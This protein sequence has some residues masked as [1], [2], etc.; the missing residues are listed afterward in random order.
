MG[1][2]RCLYRV[3]DVAVWQ[4]GFGGVFQTGIVRSAKL[5]GAYGFHEQLLSA[6][7]AYRTG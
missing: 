2:R 6:G 3:E 7:Q 5:G 1:T 4:L